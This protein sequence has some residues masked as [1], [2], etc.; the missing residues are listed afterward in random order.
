MIEIVNARKG[1][2]NHFLI[3]LIFHVFLWG[4]KVHLSPDCTLHLD[5]NI[6]YSVLP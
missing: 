1:M 2:L 6:P 3:E 4:M 5:L